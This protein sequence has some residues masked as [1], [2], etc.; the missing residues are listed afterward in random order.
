[1]FTIYKPKRLVFALTTLAVLAACE[2]VVEAELET[3]VRPVRLFELTTFREQSMRRFPANVTATQAAEISFRVAGQLISLPIKPS[4]IVDKGQLLAQLDQRDFKT[5]VS[6][7]AAEFDL[8]ESE[9]DRVQ[10]MLGRQLIAQAE[11]DRAQAKLSSARSALTLAQDR[12]SDTSIYAP[13]RGRVSDRFVENHQSIRSQQGILIL[14]DASQIDV[15]IE[16]PENIISQIEVSYLDRGYFPQVTFSGSENHYVVKY[17]EH[18]TEVSPGTQS[19]QVTFTMQTPENGQII[20]PGMGATL[21]I[22]MSRL[23]PDRKT[24]DSFLVPITSVLVNDTT[25]QAQVWV[26]SDDKVQPLTVSVLSITSNGI[27]VTGDLTIGDQLVS[28]GLGQLR[29]GM[30]VKPLARERGL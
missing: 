18:K 17:K 22:D 11:V 27:W 21:S 30:A 23:L 3:P 5:A 8:A 25:Q 1:M 7:R 12:L 19:Y 6:L 15:S 20:Y 16:L 24:K 4:D 10:Q 9:Y 29:E 14:Q 26:Y 13:F 2:P 28:A